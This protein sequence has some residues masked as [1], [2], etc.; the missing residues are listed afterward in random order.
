MFDK[1]EIIIKNKKCFIS[2]E[3]IRKLF[4]SNQSKQNIKSLNNNSNFR[5]IDTIQKINISNDHPLVLFHKPDARNFYNIENKIKK[6]LFDNKGYIDDG[7]YKR[8]L[9]KYYSHQ[10]TDHNYLKNLYH[11]QNKNTSKNNENNNFFN[12]HRP[13]FSIGLNRRTILKDYSDSIKKA[14][15]KT[16][17]KYEK[18]KNKE[19]ENKLFNSLN[20]QEIK[21]RSS[22][23]EKLTNKNI[24]ENLFNN[25]N[26]NIINLKENNYKR[27]KDYLDHHNISYENENIN[28]NIKNDNLKNLK[29]IN[30]KNKILNGPKSSINNGDKRTKIKFKNSVN[31]FEFIHKIK[32]E[33]QILQ[34]SKEKNKDSKKN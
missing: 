31:Q 10:N 13:S 5:K 20:V 21:N 34:K 6:D 18:I 29:D 28:E 17:I 26:N 12:S 25:K 2:H 14:N 33:L 19:K 1:K 8:K 23:I 27:K 32:K 4:E 22:L 15:K 30:F 9:L 7:G 3:Y 24:I 16:K 11:S